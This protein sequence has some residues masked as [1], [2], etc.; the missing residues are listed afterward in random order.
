MNWH[1]QDAKNNFSKVV[2]KARTEGPQTVTV[3]G[4][5]A[6]VVLSAEEYERLAGKKTSFVEHLLARPELDDDIWEE[7][8]K[9]PKDDRRNIDL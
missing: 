1:L 8:L 6:T 4:K 3:R 9:R 2:Q 5:P 7:V